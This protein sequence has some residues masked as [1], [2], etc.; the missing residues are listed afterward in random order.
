M[1]EG[2]SHKFIESEIPALGLYL[3]SESTKQF[4]DVVKCAKTIVWNGP[5]GVYQFKNFA[6]KIVDAK[7]GIS[8]DQMGLDFPPEITKQKSEVVQRSKTILWH[9]PAGVSEHENFANGTKCLMELVVDATERGSF[10]IIVG[11][12][13]SKACENLGAQD[14]MSHIATGYAS[15]FTLLEGIVFWC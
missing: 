9:G 10:S 1:A 5:A 4:P 6:Y 12:A 13:T 14:K 2:D 11:E 3:G 8:D 15:A 7:S